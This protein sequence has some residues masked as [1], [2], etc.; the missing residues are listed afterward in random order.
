MK[1]NMAERGWAAQTP[2]TKLETPH[3]ICGPICPTLFT[4]QWTTLHCSVTSN[5]TV[6]S[7]LDNTFV[8]VLSQTLVLLNPGVCEGTLAKFSL[9]SLLEAR[10]CLTTFSLASFT[11]NYILCVKTSQSDSV[12]YCQGICESGCASIYGAIKSGSKGFMLLN[13]PFQQ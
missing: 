6:H 1:T 12:R 7:I 11:R 13:F 3:T 5:T 8:R 10:I 2:H 4:V 9:K